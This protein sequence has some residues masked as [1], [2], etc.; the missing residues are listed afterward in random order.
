MKILVVALN[1]ANHSRNGSNTVYLKRFLSCLKPEENQN[2]TLLVC[3]EGLDIL[4]PLFPKLKYELY[5]LEH[6]NYY[7]PKS[8][9]AAKREAKKF[10]E[11]VN[12]NHY[13]CVY[14]SHFFAYFARCRFNCRKVVTIH[15]IIEL[16]EKINGLT[17]LRSYIVFRHYLRCQLKSSDKI[18]A[19][20]EYVKQ[21]I[22]KTFGI[23]DDGRIEV[24][25][26]SVAICKNS[27][28]PDDFSVKNL[29]S[30]VFTCDTRRYRR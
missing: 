1:V 19:I 30:H 2:Y 12:A 21:D 13:D 20:S 28:K 10:Q 23:I 15:D 7:S 9:F 17:Q 22:I 18:I 25:R 4:R 27:V 11:Y 24:V 5:E 14:I 8:F 3:R 26:N 16:H 6:L 29:V